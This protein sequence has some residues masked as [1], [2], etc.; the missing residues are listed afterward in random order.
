MWVPDGIPDG[1]RQGTVWC[2]R[3]GKWSATELDILKKAFSGFRKPPDNGSINQV[4]IKFPVLNKRTIP[5]IKASAWH[6][7]RTG[8]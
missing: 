1:S 2:V 8:R 3:L 5:Q 6:Q 7:I 4:Q